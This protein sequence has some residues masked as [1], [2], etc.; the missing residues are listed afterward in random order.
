MASSQTS[1]RSLAAPF[2][3]ARDRIGKLPWWVQVAILVA[4][5]MLIPLWGDDYITA[6]GVSVLTFA[7]LGLGLNIV[8]GY[9]GLL[10]L[11]YAAF[12]AIGAYTTAI[13]TV[14]LGFSFWTTLIPA[15][16]FAGIAGAILGYPTLRL[17]SDYLAIVTLGFGEIVRILFTNWDYVDGPNGVWNIPSPSVFGFDLVDQSSYYVI[18]VIL[19]VIA[20]TFARNLS[21]SRLGRGWVAVREDEFAAEAV[22]VPT[23]N[24]KLLAYVM[25]GMWAGLAGAFFASR[26]SAINPSSFTFVLSSQILIL[27]IIGGLGS[28]PGVILGAIVVVGFPEMLRGLQNGRF[29]IFAALLILIMLFR[30]GGLWPHV[31]ARRAPFVGLEDEEEKQ[32]AERP[33]K[34]QPAVAA[35]EPILRVKGLVQRFGGVRAVDD[36]GFEV[37]RGE[38]LSIIGPNGAGKTTVFNCITGVQRPK[39]GRIEFN[40]RL[41]GRLKPHSIV[42]RGMARTFQGIRLFKQM[43]VFENV[44]IGASVREQNLPWQALLHSRGE[45]RD[46]RRA[47]REARYWLRFVG[48]QDEAGRLATE[49]SYADQ[50]RVEIARALASEPMLV[51]LDE[52]AAGMNPTEKVE[53]MGMVRR[54]RDRGV[55]VVLIDHDMSLVMNVSDRVIVLDGGR[56]I[57]GG[58]PADVQNNQ[59][60]IEAYLGRDDIEEDEPAAQSTRGA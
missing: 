31:R 19:V 15:I 16:A 28:L 52:P 48:L 24:L 43:A 2:S 42:S 60:V 10:D 27:I 26:V 59:R 21:Y 37:R 23:L 55:T 32:A 18:G 39:A 50:R 5:S 45:R 44:M 40:G 7:M 3:R 53:L 13:M 4:L 11:G 51:L 41:L 47:L 56:V 38:I 57:A 30:P 46:E 54:I 35:G 22:G 6:I 33:F 17:R 49:L 34:L 1:I 58:S 12:F 8:V 36:V 20:M 14:K 9:A 29:L 25:G